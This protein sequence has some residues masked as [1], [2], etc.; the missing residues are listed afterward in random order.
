MPEVVTAGEPLVALVPQ[1]LG[2]LRSQRLLE[3][4]VGGAEVNVAV[5]LARLGVRVGFV[6]QV[7]EDELGAMVMEKLRAE[8]VD[9]THFQRVAGFT[10]LYLREYLPLGKGRAF[11]Y[12]K[13]S[14]ASNLAP[15]AFDPSYLQGAAFLHLSGI[16]PALSPSCRAFS[17]WA[18]EEAKKRGV[19]VSLDVNYRQALWSPQEAL[20]FLDEALP[21]TDLVFLSEEEA[22]LLFGD[23]ERALQR[24]RAP[25]VVLR[26][27]PRGAVALGEGGRAEE[28]AF[29]VAAVDPVGA[30][31]AFAAGYLAGH[32]WGLPVRERLRL[33]NLLGACVAA[34]RGDHEGAPYREDL[35]VLWQ[36]GTGMV[37]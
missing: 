36:Q 20:A 28:E 13:G 4:Y 24:L 26:R 12:R 3:A 14:A 1:D 23:E 17:L 19:R 32:L 16:T 10:G 27:G 2:R 5:A 6:G 33:G 31:D 15:G 29:P 35:E 11:Y 25:E 18:M 30:G 37:R 22:R 21:L 7:G 8:G 9:L 34:N